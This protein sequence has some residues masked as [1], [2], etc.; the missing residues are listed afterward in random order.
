MSESAP[1]PEQSH[2]SIIQPTVGQGEETIRVTQFKNASGEGP[3]HCEDG[4]TLFMSLAAR[5]VHYLQKQDGKTHTGLYQKGDLLVTPANTPLF[6][7]WEGEE[8]CLQIQLTDSFL[9]RIA[10]ETFNGNGE[11]LQLMPAFHQQDTQVIAIA[12][13]I[14]QEF[15][16]TS[17]GN[18]LCVDSLANLLAVNL[19][20]QFATTQP[21]LPTYGGGLPQRQLMTILD[22]IDAH[23]DQEIKLA[24]LAALL[25]MSQFH[26]S[27][28]F[29]QSMGLTPYQ[30]LLQQ[31]V[32]RAK[33]LLKHT[34]RFIA[35]IALEC[36]FNSHS[37]LS[38]QFRQLTGITP[39]AFRS[40]RA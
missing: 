4:H 23:L 40:G 9:K 14:L 28:L 6:V 37:H 17:A 35:D 25:D 29:K 18:Q 13:L 39:K 38:K 1:L 19:L 32:E 3:Y 11:R 12:N 10:G 24:N 33:Q 31:R 34:D 22:Y 20:R 5:P 2:P 26:F 15:Q 36:G 30:Y 21:Q 7:R 16:Q 27:H 8:H